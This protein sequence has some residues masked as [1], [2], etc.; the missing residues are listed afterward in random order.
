[1]GCDLLEDWGET[2][3]YLPLGFVCVKGLKGLVWPVG[4]ILVRD[5]HW[6]LRNCPAGVTKH[7]SVCRLPACAAMGRRGALLQEA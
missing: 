2:P 7:P 6:V 3:P 4:M 5:T 1:M